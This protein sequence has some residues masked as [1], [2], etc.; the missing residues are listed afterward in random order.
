M[1]V[2]CR[3]WE[4]WV[5]NMFFR[6]SYCLIN[7]SNTNWFFEQRY[8]LGRELVVLITYTQIVCFNRK[9]INK[10]RFTKFNWKYYWNKHILCNPWRWSR[11][12][13][14]VL[15][16]CEYIFSINTYNDSHLM[17]LFEGKGSHFC[18]IRIFVIHVTGNKTLFSRK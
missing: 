12:F 2:R 14:L 15:V 3:I 6:A 5:A 1:T 10:I 11:S 9:S 13:Y 18:M 7:C 17:C 4:W 16:N 8:V